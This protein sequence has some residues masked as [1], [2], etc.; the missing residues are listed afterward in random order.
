MNKLLLITGNE[1]ASEN[2]CKLPQFLGYETFST[3]NGMK[4]I[5]I[6]KNEKPSLIICDVS[7]P[8]IDGYCVTNILN[9]NPLTQNIPVLILN[10]SV[11]P[12]THINEKNGHDSLLSATKE[13]EMLV[14]ATKRD[15]NN[16]KS[17]NKEYFHN[18]DN[19]LQLL[20]STSPDKTANDLATGYRT[21]SFNKRENIYFEGDIP[22][23]VYLVKKGKIKTVKLGPEGKEFIVGI[24]EKGEFFGYIA[25]LEDSIYPDTA[26]AAEESEVLLI[27][28]DD[29]LSLINSDQ[30]LGRHFIK[31]LANDISDIEERLM[32]LA[33]N[34][35][36]A[37]VAGAL[38]QLKKKHHNKKDS[39]SYTLHVSRD[40]LA[41]LIG[42]TT[43]SLIRTLTDFKHENI[44]DTDIGEIKILD[45]KALEK[46]RR[47]S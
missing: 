10:F 23:M 16:G 12:N 21:R 47:L 39:S 36:R 18:L 8:D 44:V 7:L 3:P 17:E 31:L 30:Q 24:H 46:I 40:D 45:T 41:G 14:S 9:K 20:S 38:L 33:F 4:G 19:L 22:N 27:P 29:F 37:R 42:T 1:A 6:A 13:S 26:V 25:V 5:E 28:K 43:E 11:E 34:S 32:T 15:A 35:V 2:I